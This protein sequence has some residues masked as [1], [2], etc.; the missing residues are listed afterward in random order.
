MDI[1]TAERCETRARRCMG[2]FQGIASGDFSERW[3]E[4][5]LYHVESD[6]INLLEEVKEALGETGDEDRGGA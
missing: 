2:V 5:N 3:I 1:Y 6:L 4:R